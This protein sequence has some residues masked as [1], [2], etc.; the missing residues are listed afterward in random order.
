M[1]AVRAAED[2]VRPLLADGV[3][4]AAVN[5]PTSVVV[6]GDADAVDAVARRFERTARLRVSHA[7]HSAHMDPMLEEFRA[8][9]ENL[10]HRA[11]RIP[12]VSNLTGD[13]A[14]DELATADYW[15]RHVREAVRFH[16]GVRTLDARGVSRFLELGPDGVLT[17]LG[18][19]CLDGDDSLFRSAQ[20][21]EHPPLRHLADTVNALRDRG[22]ALDADTAERELHQATASVL[23]VVPWVLSAKSAQALAGQAGRLLERVGSL[24]SPV[25]VGWSLAVSRSVFEHRAVVVGADRAGLL[26][27]VA[28]GQAPAGV[29]TGQASGGRAAFLFSGQGSQRAGMGREL[30]DAYPVFADALDAVCAE[31]D[32]HLDTSVREVVFDGSELLDQTVF[33][34]AGLFALEVALFRLLEHWG[35]T[36]D[37]LLGHSIGELAAAHVAGVWS[38]EDAARLV[39]ARGRLMQA[40]PTGGA[41]IAVQATED[42]ITAHLIDGVSIAAVNGP[43]SVVI[44]GDEDAVA[45]IAARFDKSK[46]LNVSHAFHSPRMDPMLQEFRTVAESLTYQAPRIPV[47]SNLTGDV[48]GEELA[49]AE[50]WVRHVRQA[51]RFHDG[52]RHLAGLGASTYVEVGP[53]GTLTALA[54]QATNSAPEPGS[55][56]AAAAAFVPA[57]RKS[58]PEPESLVTALAELHVRGTTVDWQAYYAGSGARRVEL[59]TYAFQ[60]QRYWP[61]PS[62]TTPPQATEAGDAEFWEAVER[63][64]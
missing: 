24:G 15:V 2:A 41:M 33:T 11:P 34:Q 52:M 26:A 55:D 61:Q 27:A 22:L 9:A 16:D 44:S 6:S 32:R 58:R 31:L 19:S 23:P 49:T 14:G 10:T 7:F 45:E 42:E 3:A 36:P 28:Q 18:R 53:G 25:D 60:H 8:V 43:T 21:R 59:P 57:L 56:G 51:V 64:D 63:A 50:Y 40:L 35:V 37:Y 12:V 62:T 54:Q 1:V 47:V 4:V 29:V 17:A 13:V 46:R 39:A 20:H 38:L 48:A 5:G 30:Y